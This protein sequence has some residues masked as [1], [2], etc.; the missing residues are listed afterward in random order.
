MKKLQG[1]LTGEM[2]LVFP[3]L[4]LL[5]V[6]MMTYGIASAAALK[7]SIAVGEGLMVVETAVRKGQAASKAETA[8]YAYV[9]ERASHE[10]ALSEVEVHCTNTYF[11][12]T[13]EVKAEG[14]LFSLPLNAWSFAQ[15][16]NVVDPVRFR[17]RVDLISE[18]MHP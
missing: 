6:L 12:R 7:S 10:G 16:K 1:S 14:W 2:A 13:G 8:A 15:K 4:L 3:V 18:A 17:N 11:V 5:L 9:S